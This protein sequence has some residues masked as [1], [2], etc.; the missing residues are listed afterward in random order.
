M[1]AHSMDLV[2]IRVIR[3]IR[4]LV[5][6]PVLM[7]EEAEVTSVMDGCVPTAANYVHMLTCL[8]VSSI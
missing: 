1:A 7:V 6:D 3:L 8:Y 2:V 5:V 4:R